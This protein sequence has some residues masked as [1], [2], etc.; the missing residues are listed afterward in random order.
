[1]RR[2]IFIKMSLHVKYYAKRFAQFRSP[3]LWELMEPC[4]PGNPVDYTQD[5]KYKRAA[6][7]ISKNLS[8]FIKKPLSYCLCK[9]ITCRFGC[10]FCFGCGVRG[11]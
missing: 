1:M 5:P 9:V 11:I 6:Q 4:P 3:M 8:Y 7:G 10:C 2:Q